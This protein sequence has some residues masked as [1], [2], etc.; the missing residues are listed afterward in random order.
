[1]E[2]GFYHGVSSA[3]IAGALEEAGH[4]HLTTIDLL[5]ARD[6]KPNIEHVLNNLGLASLVTWHY[7]PCSY[8]WRLMRLLQSY[9]E[10]AFDLCYI[11][12]GH[13][14]YSTG[15]GFC[16]VSRLLKSGGWVIFDDIDWTHE[17]STIRETARVK[18]MPADE[19]SLPQ[20]RLVYD[21]LV[22]RDPGFDN[23]KVDGQWAFAR[24]K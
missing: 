3:Y 14:W 7:E 20:V 23:F 13:T 8:N 12:G 15:F 1:L 9:S 2:L 24:K 11:D 17:N 10:P 18:A 4:G 6:L 22:K 19:R 16:L 21:L 5:D